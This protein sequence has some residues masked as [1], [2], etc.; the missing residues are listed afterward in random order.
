MVG[1]RHR[2]QSPATTEAPPGKHGEKGSRVRPWR[3]R[4]IPLCQASRL[5]RRRV[6]PALTCAAR[7]LFH[8][9]L[10]AAAAR[11]WVSL[12]EPPRPTARLSLAAAAA[13]RDRGAATQDGAAQI[14][15]APAAPAALRSGP[16]S[17][18][19]PLRRSHARGSPRT[20]A[21]TPPGPKP[22]SGERLPRCQRRRRQFPSLDRHSLTPPLL[23]CDKRSPPVSCLKRRG[24]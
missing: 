13:A 18:T 4:P 16:R 1:R 8:A 10:P 12:L 24:V 21:H 19:R 22:A 14:T 5:R 11:A 7:A 23:H 9:L 17:R 15:P 3:G 6:P 2:A 20:R